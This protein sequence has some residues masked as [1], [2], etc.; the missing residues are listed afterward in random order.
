M[1]LTLSDLTGSYTVPSADRN[2][3]GL[4]CLNKCVTI[5]SSIK[6]YADTEMT[7]KMSCLV[8]GS[9]DGE[10]RRDKDNLSL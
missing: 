2:L 10:L 1:A 3:I 4:W 6:S 8:E 9:G 5:L 7:P